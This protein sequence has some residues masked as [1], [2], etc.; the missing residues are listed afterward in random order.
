MDAHRHGSRQWIS[1][2]ATSQTKLP[3]G[4][5]RIRPQ[6]SPL[7]VASHSRISRALRTSRAI[8]QR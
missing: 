4:G 2:L 5:G 1:V 7:T 3:Y 8:A 6:V